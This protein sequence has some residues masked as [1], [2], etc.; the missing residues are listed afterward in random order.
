VIIAALCSPSWRAPPFYL[1]NQHSSRA[2]GPDGVV[3]AAP[4]IPART[5]IQPGAASFREIRSTPPRRTGSITDPAAAGKV[6]AVHSRSVS[7]MNMIR[8]PPASPA[9]ILR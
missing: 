6:L 4:V 9:S 5:P 8:P 3:V 2:P 1:I 7:R